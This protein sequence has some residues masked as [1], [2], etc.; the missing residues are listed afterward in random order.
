MKGKK[1]TKIRPTPA[2]KKAPV[3]AETVARVKELLDMFGRRVR[4]AAA[5]DQNE[6]RISEW[7]SGKRAPTPGDW[8]RLGKLALEYGL[9]EP[10]FFWEQAGIDSQTVMSMAGKIVKGQYELVGNTVPVRRFRF[11]EQGREE[12]G[13]PIPLPAEFIPNPAS[14]VCIVTDDK[15]TGVVDSPGAVFILDESEKDAPDLTPF[16]RQ[17]VF[18]RFDAE[19]DAQRL[20]SGIYVGRLSLVEPSLRRFRGE[21]RIADAR[22]HPL[23]DILNERTLTLGW[24]IDRSVKEALEAVGDEPEPEKNPLVVAAWKESVERARKGLR[25][26][27]GWSIMGRVLGRLK[28]EGI[29]NDQGSGRL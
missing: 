21:A 5:V 13:P 22:F 1:R 16:W 6:S 10:F 11:T 24:W 8:I 12:A 28:L 25:L 27:R 15:A 19:A 20:D 18:A 23:A 7:L 9:A 17:V 26:D 3:N 29:Q 2:T 14:T 4:L